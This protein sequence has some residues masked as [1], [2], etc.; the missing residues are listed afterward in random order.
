M[1]LLRCDA[2]SEE[3]PVSQ[4]DRAVEGVQVIS[5]WWMLLVLCCF[6]PP[7]GCSLLCSHIGDD[8]WFSHML[9]RKAGVFR[10]VSDWN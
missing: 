5:V 6:F 4:L 7:V 1:Y 10:I 3:L 8:F 2:V 9:D